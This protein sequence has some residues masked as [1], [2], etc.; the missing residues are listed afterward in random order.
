MA[1]ISTIDGRRSVEQHINDFIQLA[2]ASRDSVVAMQAVLLAN[3][4]KE[5]ARE[6]AANTDT[7]NMVPV[8]PEW[9]MQ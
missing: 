8:G 5:V 2:R 9:G 4:L 1:S 7:T 3:R 6:K